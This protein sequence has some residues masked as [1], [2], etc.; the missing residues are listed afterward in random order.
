MFVGYVPVVFAVTELVIKVFHTLSLGFAVALA[1][2]GGLG[3]GRDTPE[4][5]ALPTMRKMVC[6]DVVV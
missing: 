5:V 4:Y 6:R 3:C 2:M 1:W